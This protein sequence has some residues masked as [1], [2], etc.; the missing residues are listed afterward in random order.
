MGADTRLALTRTLRHLLLALVATLLLAVAAGAAQSAASPSRLDTI[1]NFE[2]APPWA[3]R[4]R[5]SGWDDG[6]NSPDPGEFGQFAK[7]IALRYS[8]HFHGI[9]RVR[10]YQAW[11]EPNHYRHLNPQ[12]EATKPPASV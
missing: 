12:F 11:N 7:A 5:G 1:F 9:P 4:T 8:G 2:N 10:Y 6:T 3:E